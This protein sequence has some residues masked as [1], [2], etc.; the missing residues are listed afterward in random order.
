MKINRRQWQEECQADFVLKVVEQHQRNYML[1]AVPGAG[2]TR[3]AER[4][5]KKLLDIAR[6]NRVVVLVPTYDLKIQWA[7]SAAAMGIPLDPKWHGDGQET[8]DYR[9]VVCTYQSLAS[10]HQVHRQL[11]QRIPTFTIFDEIHH[12]SDDGQLWGNAAQCAF[13]HAT[14]TMGLSGTILRTDQSKVPFVQ[15]CEVPGGW[16]PIADVNYPYLRALREKVCREL[17]FE[18]YE[19]DATWKSSR[20]GEQHARIDESLPEHLDGHRLRAFIDPDNE[21]MRKILRDAD[22]KLTECRRN[23][24]KAAGLVIAEDIT[25]ARK[26]VKLLREI[27]GEQ[28]ALVVSEYENTD[29]VV[30]IEQFKRSSQRWIVAVKKVSEGIDIRR[31][32]VLVYAS[33]YVTDMFTVQVFGRVIRSPEGLNDGDDVPP[34]FIYL[35]G[36]PRLT[37]VAAAFSADVEL[38]IAEKRAERDASRDRNASDPSADPHVIVSLSATARESDVL[39]VVGVLNPLLMSEARELKRHNEDGLRDIHPEQIAKVLLLDRMQ[40]G[41]SEK[42]TPTHV[43]DDAPAEYEIRETLRTKASRLASRLDYSWGEPQGTAHAHWRRMG[44]KPQ[45]EATIEELRRKIDWLEAELAK[46]V[47]DT[48]N[49]GFDF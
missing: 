15:Y 2:K 47:K 25:H 26:F 21:A 12:L 37:E 6:V 34:S 5:A 33:D 45:N 35:P 28:P 43:E 42:E 1:N 40:K 8:A 30:T 46:C 24:P 23:D 29:E 36:H 38:F 17:Y 31:L 13:E 20:Y 22:Q 9:G 16:R 27:T 48:A 18:I 32:R 10:Q 3:A 49:R 11:C 41:G 7:K 4:A 44:G 14:H 19:G 39:S